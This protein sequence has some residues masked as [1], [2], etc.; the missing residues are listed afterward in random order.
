M[1]EVSGTTDLWAGEGIG[2]KRF[3]YQAE[4]YPWGKPYSAA[5]DAVTML[6][7]GAFRRRS[8][9][10]EHVVD[11]NTGF[12]RRRD[13]EASAANFTGELEEFTIIELDQAILADLFAEP[14]LPSGPF[15]VTPQID[16]A[17]RMLFRCVGERPDDA[18]IE[19]HV[20]HFV[21]AIVGQCRPEV[22]R[23]GRPTTDTN[24][25][26]L[27]TDACEVLHLTRG[28]ISLQVLAR[29]VGSSPFHLSR[30]FRAMTGTTISQYRLRLRVHEVL[31]RLT[32]GEED[33]SALANAVGFS[34]HSHMT[35][36]VVA[37]LG[38]APSVL[39][40]RL[41]TSD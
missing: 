10:V 16:L 26:A 37:Q 39:R 9:G 21:A 30:L 25:R 11:V 36:S 15:R 14:I 7:R 1:W 28:N 24:R 6:R 8:A 22:V 20:V 38:V 31:D 3:W 32:D 40:Q 27:V 34:D 18:H 17:H 5:T 41:R 13:E 33:L 2:V 35:R 29:R 4:R 23:G 12:F 19:E